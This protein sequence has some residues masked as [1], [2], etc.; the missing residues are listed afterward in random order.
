MEE[1]RV[2]E[3]SEPH[4]KKW[5]STNGKAIVCGCL[6]GLIAFMAGWFLVWLVL[7]IARYEPLAGGIS[8]VAG[9]CLGVL[10]FLRVWRRMREN[11]RNIS[12]GQD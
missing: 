9:V 6:C 5:L 10:V 3:Q 7:P 1:R 4:T 2:I 11:D 12:A 8:A